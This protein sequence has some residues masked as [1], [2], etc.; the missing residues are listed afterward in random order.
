[1]IYIV[2]S[3]MQCAPF[4]YRLYSINWTYLSL[5]MSEPPQLHG[6]FVPTKYLLL[7]N[8]IIMVVER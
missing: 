5:V 7:N 2:Q 1:M 3:S 6:N 4:S 8:Q